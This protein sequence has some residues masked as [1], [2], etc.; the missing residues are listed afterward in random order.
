LI[1]TAYVLGLW[2]RLRPVPNRK[3]L[4]I[5]MELKSEEEVSKSSLS[6]LDLA[7]EEMVASR[8]TSKRRE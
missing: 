3:C 6:D 4:I 1:D 7:S 2:L 8:A 5:E